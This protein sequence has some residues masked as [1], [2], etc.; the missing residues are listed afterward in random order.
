MVVIN[1][2]Q[3]KGTAQKSIQE[4]WKTILPHKKRISKAERRQKTSPKT[5]NQSKNV[6][7]SITPPYSA[8]SSLVSACSIY[9]LFTTSFTWAKAEEAA[10]PN[11]SAFCS[12]LSILSFNSL[13]LATMLRR[14]F[15]HSSSKRV[16]TTISILYLSHIIFLSI[17]RTKKWLT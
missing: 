13:S 10:I 2:S 9:N 1:A 14:Y 4:E 5:L 3:K 8:K 7:D 17:K 15:M 11:P 6:D 12:I 16:E